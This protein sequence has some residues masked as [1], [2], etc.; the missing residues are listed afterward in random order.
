MKWIY[1]Y[2]SRQ[3]KVVAVIVAFSRFFYNNVVVVAEEL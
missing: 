1:L 2:F 3:I